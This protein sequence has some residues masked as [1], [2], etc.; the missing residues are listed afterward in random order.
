[1]RISDWSSDVCSSDL[2][3]LDSRLYVLSVGCSNRQTFSHLS[4]C[5]DTLTLIIH[6]LDGNCAISTAWL[7]PP[8]GRRVVSSR[9]RIG[10]YCQSSLCGILIYSLLPLRILVGRR[11]GKWCVSRCK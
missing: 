5:H 1:M 9:S 7:I 3:A 6:S 4:P 2:T 8:A 11:V 10:S